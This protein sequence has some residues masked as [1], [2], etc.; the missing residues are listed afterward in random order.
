MRE[1]CLRWFGHVQKRAINALVRNNELI[2]VEETEKD[3]GRKIK[4]KK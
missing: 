2:H 3:R 4:K 1:S